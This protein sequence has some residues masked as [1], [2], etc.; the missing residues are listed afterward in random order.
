MQGKIT[1]ITPPDFFENG[2][3]SVLLC[4]ISDEEQEKISRWLSRSDLTENINIYLYSG[5]T[6]VSWFLYALNRCEFKYI[7][8]D[9]VND[10]TIWLTGYILGKNNFSYKTENENVAS[11][12]SFISNNRTKSIEQFM[13]AIFDKQTP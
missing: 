13:E 8:L 7:N 4:H 9:N 1:L 12:I 3:T 2:N 5:E 10:V 6:N 11:L